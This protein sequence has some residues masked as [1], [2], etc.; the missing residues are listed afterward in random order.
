[1]Q[2]EKRVS[3]TRLEVQLKQEE[4]EEPGSALNKDR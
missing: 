1:M 4:Q 3:I 2:R